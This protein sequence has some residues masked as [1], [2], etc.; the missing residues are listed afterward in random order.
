MDKKK[1]WIEWFSLLL[2][3]VGVVLVF[4]S[5]WSDGWMIARFVITG[6]LLIGWGHGID[7]QK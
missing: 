1:G 6:F 5:V 7:R 4:A 3:A 2:T